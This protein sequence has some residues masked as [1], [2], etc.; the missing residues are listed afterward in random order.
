M[1]ARGPSVRSFAIAIGLQFVG[2]MPRRTSGRFLMWLCVACVIFLVACLPTVHIATNPNCGEDTL[3]R[4]VGLCLFE[5][6]R[7]EHSLYI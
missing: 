7:A 6:A 2:P 1:P 3:W 5:P 4:R